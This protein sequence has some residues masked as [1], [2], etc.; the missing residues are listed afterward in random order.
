MPSFAVQSPSSGRVIARRRRQ[1]SRN[2]L[3]KLLLSKVLRL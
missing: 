1:V 2:F 3:R